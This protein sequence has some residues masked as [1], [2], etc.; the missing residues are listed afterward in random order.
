ML[1][2]YTGSLAVLKISMMT[3]EDSGEYAIVAENDYGKVCWP[4]KRPCELAFCKKLFSSLS[5]GCNRS[6]LLDFRKPKAEIKKFSQKFPKEI[7]FER[8]NLLNKS[9]QKGAAPHSIIW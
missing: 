2:Q 7:N 3:P 9:P 6:V 4:T 8:N 5:K 1:K